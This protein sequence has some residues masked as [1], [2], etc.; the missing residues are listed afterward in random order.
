MSSILSRDLRAWLSG[1]RSVRRATSI[2]A[3]KFLLRH[4]FAVAMSAIAIV[5]VLGALAAVTLWQSR[6]CAANATRRRPRASGLRSTA[7]ARIAGF[8]RDTF[9]QA[10]PGLET[11]GLLARDLL[12]RGK[13][14]LDGLD[15]QQDVREVALLLAESDAN[16]GLL[17]ESDATFRKYADA[18]DALA[19]T[20]ADVQMRAGKLRLSNAL[21]LDE[22]SRRLDAALA[23]LARSADTPEAQ[24]DVARLHERLLVRRSEFKRAA[25]VLEAAWRRHGDA[26]DPAASLQ[27]RVDLGERAAQRQ[28]RRGRAPHP[29]T[30]ST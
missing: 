17:R 6:R 3:R 18:I 19:A 23:T 15:S 12:E 21:T 30:T 13:R 29:A 28:T 7:T 1:H 20:D 22:D 9:E 25:E 10:D 16:L 27:L 24:V 4:R 5:G 14:R 8:L 11:G 2:A 26:L